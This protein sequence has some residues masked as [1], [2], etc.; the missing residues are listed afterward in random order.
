MGG[1]VGLQ[2]VLWAF[3]LAVSQILRVA[4]ARGVDVGAVVVFDVAWVGW[5]S[6]GLKRGVCGQVDAANVA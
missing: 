6:S 4:F 1:F 5:F 3:S 2:V